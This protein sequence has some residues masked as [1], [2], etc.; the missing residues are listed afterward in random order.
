MSS[1]QHL[2]C[3]IKYLSSAGQHLLENDNFLLNTCIIYNVTQYTS[4]DTI[5]VTYKQES[6]FL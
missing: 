5:R 6:S 2:Q 4:D 3:I 1:I